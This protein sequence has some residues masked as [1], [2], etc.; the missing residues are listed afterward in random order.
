MSVRADKVENDVLSRLGQWLRPAG[1]RWWGQHPSP[2]ESAVHE[3]DK[4]LNE[5]GKDAYWL[6]CLCERRAHGALKRHWHE[7][8]VGIERRTGRRSPAAPG[9]KN[10]SVG[11][12]PNKPHVTTEGEL[13][14]PQG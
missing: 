9:E 14:R 12:A 7:G 5:Y 6:A 11:R 13:A 1:W 3:A 4:L 2:Q 8:A 10:G